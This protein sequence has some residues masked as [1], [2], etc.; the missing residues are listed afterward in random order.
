MVQEAE[1]ELKGIVR[2]GD[3]D[4]PGHIPVGHAL[5][6]VKGSS[7]MFA[8]AVSVVLKLD[9]KKKVG[10]LSDSES[11]K[12]EDC[13]RNPTK[14]GIPVWLL[15]RRTEPET[16]EN[17]HLISSDLD[18]AKKFDI[19]RLQKIKTYKGVRHSLG[20]KKLRG[21]KTKSTGRKGKTLGVQR[22]KKSGKKG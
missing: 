18:L 5:T 16:G 17:K 11:Q 7:F 10:L 1:T 15:N 19:R 3:K 6:K 12:I 13:L 21:Q 22:K 4:V 14:Y 8:N 20:S 9:R 2:I